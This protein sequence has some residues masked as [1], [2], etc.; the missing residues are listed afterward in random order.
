MQ[1]DL[2]AIA[3]NNSVPAQ[4]QRPPAR[5]VSTVRASNRSPLRNLS[6]SHQSSNGAIEP[7]NE[8][9]NLSE[10]AQSIKR[11]LPDASTPQSKRLHRDDA[12]DSCSSMSPHIPTQ[13]AAFKIDTSGK[14]LN[15]NTKTF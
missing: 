2:Q 15:C 13:T 9:I 12:E 8:P 14:Y 1:P 4:Y 5:D 6:N 3:M 11:D 10:S 7:Q